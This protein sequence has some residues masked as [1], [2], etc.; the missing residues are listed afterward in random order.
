MKDKDI[1]Y[2]EYQSRVQKFDNGWYWFVSF[3]YNGVLHYGDGVEDTKNAAHEAIK[4][5]RNGRCKQ[6]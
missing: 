2:N 3:M 1:I 6:S 5:F 4:E